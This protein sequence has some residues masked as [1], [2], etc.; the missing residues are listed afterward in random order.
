MPQMLHACGATK[1]HLLLDFLTVG[2]DTPTV[3]FLCPVP[4]VVKLPGGLEGV[5]V[6]LGGKPGGE[7]GSLAAVSCATRRLLVSTSSA[8]VFVSAAMVAAWLSVVSDFAT[9][10]LAS[11]LNGPDIFVL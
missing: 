10:A 2:H 1:Y 7:K 6:A 5:A 4:T 11:A 9:A 8:L 3:L